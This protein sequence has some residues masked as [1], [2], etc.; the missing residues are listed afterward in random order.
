MVALV[1]SG[2]MRISGKGGLRLAC[3]RLAMVMM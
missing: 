1:G 3:S 2:N